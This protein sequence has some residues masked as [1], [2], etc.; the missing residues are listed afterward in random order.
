MQ[1][2]LAREGGESR[3]ALGLRDLPV[4]L[5][6]SAERSEQSLEGAYKFKGKWLRLI[7]E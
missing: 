1:M 6:L 7:S 3:A 4:W 5:L 2:P